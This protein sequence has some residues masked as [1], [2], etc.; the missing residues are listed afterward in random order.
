[1]LLKFISISFPLTVLL[2]SFLLFQI[3]PVAG[4]IVTPKFGGT[5]GIW[6]LLLV[7]F[8]LVVLGGYGITYV[9]TKL[10][11]RTQA[12]VYAAMAVASAAMVFMSTSQTWA[13]DGVTTP[14]ASLMWVLLVHLAVPCLWLA[15]ISGVI[16]VWYEQTTKNNPYILYSVSNIG[17]LSALLSYP[18]LIEPSMTVSTT[19]EIWQ[20]SYAVLALL[21]CA[22][23]A[24]VW[25]RAPSAPAKLSSDEV[26]TPKRFLYWTWLSA[27]GSALLLTITGFITQDVAPV[28][29]LWIPPL[30][31]YLLTFIIAFAG[32]SYYKRNLSIGLTLA[33]GVFF[34][35]LIFWM[36]RMPLL[37]T[38][39]FC[40]G[41]LFFACLMC[42][43]ELYSDKPEVADLP[44]FYF[45]L[46]LGGAVGGITISIISPLILSV[47]VERLLVLT[48]VMG[49]AGYFC[50]RFELITQTKTTRTSGLYAVLLMTGFM[51]LCCGYGME[52]YRN[53]NLLAQE[54]NFYGSATVVREDDRVALYHGN[55]LHGY[56]LHDPAL[57]RSLVR[58][59]TDA[60]AVVNEAVRSLLKRPVNYGLV[61]LGAGSLAAYGLPG[62]RMTFYEL[63]PKMNDIAHKNFTFV[64]DSPATIEIVMGD[65]RASLEREPPRNYDML[66]VDAFNSDAIP[67]HLL[68]VE[69]LKAYM[70]H[71]TPGGAVLFH[72]TNRYVNLPPVLA[73]AAQNLHVDC[74]LIQRDNIRYILLTHNQ[75][76]I[77][78]LRPAEKRLARQVSISPAAPNLTAPWTDDFS[79]LFSALTLR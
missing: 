9:L 20:L 22:A 63:D 36:N 72:V 26:I 27:L 78:A 11:V 34:P 12:G 75:A 17:S 64:K 60:V 39:I 15:T 1:V 62:D 25:V 48:C 7:F 41:F 51:L 57:K 65:A 23:A 37:N 71:I 66:I 40:A 76:L 31:I 30:A 54:R 56:Q 61:G 47:F 58:Y 53:R 68:S 74:V 10:P 38:L 35:L 70:K 32:K 59:Y 29:M 46:A 33:L 42:H 4:K 5:A 21:C 3:E 8:Q 24:S 52:I 45:A 13:P 50:F 49:L 73:N 16:Q 19:F 67:I 55:T 14:E 18:V 43:G 69:A 79:N 2:G 28:P 77:K 44:L 6:C